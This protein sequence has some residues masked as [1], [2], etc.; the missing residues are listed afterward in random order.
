[1]STAAWR[2]MNYVTSWKSPV[3][4]QSSSS[5]LVKLLW[6]PGTILTSH[7]SITAEFSTSALSLFSSLNTRLNLNR[8]RKGVMWGVHLA[9]RFTEMKLCQCLSL[10]Q[11]SKKSTLKISV[12]SPNSSSITKTFGT[13]LMLSTFT[14]CVSAKRTAITWSA[15]SVRRRIRI[16]TSIYH[17]S[18]YFQ[19]GRI[20]A[21]E[22]SLLIS[23]IS[24][25]WLKVSRVRRRSLWVTLDTVHTSAT[26]AIAS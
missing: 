9:M 8:T 20:V 12:T 4:R 16:M 1:M 26:G 23:A 5:S 17:V 14:Y 3:L 6:K 10:M 24:C 19:P 13:K 22:S 18:W 25:H 21:M 2:R 7:R 11:S 15:T